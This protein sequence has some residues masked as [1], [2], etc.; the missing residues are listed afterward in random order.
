MD[1]LITKDIIGSGGG[2]GGGGAPYI[3][4]D[5]LQSDSIVSVIDVLSEGEIK[6]LVNG[7]K[8]I[9][10]DGTPIK[11]ADDTMAYDVE[12]AER[13]GLPDQSYIEGFPGS[14]SLHEANLVIKKSQPAIY[15]VVNPLSNSAV[16][17]I[18]LTSG[19]YQQKTNGDVIGGSV[20]FE[21]HT[22]D[23]TGVYQYYNSIKITGKS[24]S[25]YFESHEVKRPS[26]TGQW[27]IKVI[28]VTEDSDTAGLT[29]T[30][31]LVNVIEVIDQTQAYP[32]I[33][34][35]GLKV[36]ARSTNNQVPVRTY[37]VDG[38]ICHIPSNYDPV[39]AT[40]TG[41]W[42]GTFKR[43]WTNNPVWI[44]YELLIN[45][46]FGCGRWVSPDE[47]DV[48]SFYDASVYCD[49]RVDNGKGQLER[50]F[51]FDFKI[52][53]ANDAVKVLNDVAGSCN[54][55]LI[56]E[57]SLYRIQQDR[58]ASPV[59][60]LT[61]ANV[62]DGT[63]VYAGTPN[64]G[65]HTIVNVTYFDRENQHL[66]Q[67]TTVEAAPS[68]LE[69]YNGPNVVN[70]QALGAVTESQAIRTGRWYLETALNQ[71]EVA[72]F[73][74]SFNAFGLRL[75]DVIKIHDE[76]YSARKEQGRVLSVVTQGSTNK[77]YLDRACTY[78]FGDKLSIFDGLDVETVSLTTSGTH[79]YIVLPSNINVT[80]GNVFAFDSTVVG[81]QFRITEIN[82][83]ESN[84]LD[85]VA[86]F[87]DPSKYARIESGITVEQP[88]YT[89]IS[90]GRIKPPTNLTFMLSA[91]V[92][93]EGIR[94]TL[95]VGWTQ[96]VGVTIK[97]YQV[98]WRKDN[99]SWTTSTTSNNSFDIDNVT[100]ANYDVK[101]QAVGI[102]GTTSTAL[103]GTYSYSLTGGTGSLLNPVTNLEV[104][105]VG[106]YTFYDR[107]LDITWA[108]PIQNNVELGAI[109]KDFR[110]DIK[111]ALTDEIIYTDYSPAVP[112]G[113]TRAYTYLYDK[114]K[115]LNGGAAKREIKVTVYC[116]DTNNKISVGNTKTFYN[117]PIPAPSIIVTPGVKSL[118][119]EPSTRLDRITHPDYVETIYCVSDD[120]SFIPS[121]D[122][123]VARGDI[124]FYM[125]TGVESGTTYYCSV[126]YSDSFGEPINWSPVV[127][128]TPA[129]PA[130][131]PE[132]EVLPNSPSD[133][134]GHTGVMYKAPGT[135]EY[136]LYGWDG[137]KWMNT[138]DGGYL[139][140]YSVV[141]SKIY[142]EDLRAISANLGAI[143]SGS[144]TFD[145]TSFIRGGAVTYGVGTG[146]WQG[147]H[148]DT[149]KWR[150]G[151]PGGAGAAWDGT[152]FV[153]YGH[154]G[155]ITLQS[156]QSLTA[157]WLTLL[158]KPSSLSAISA[159]EA[160]KLNGIQAG[161]TVGAPAG[162]L[163]A[164]VDATNLAGVF[165]NFNNSN[166]QNGTPITAPTVLADGT[167]VDHTINTDSS[168]DISFEWTW[169]GNEADI[170]GF[171]VYVY[172]T[173]SSSVYSFGTS[174]AAE[175]VYTVPAQKRAFILFGQPA[176]K[177]YTFGVRAYRK[178]DKN[179]AA[180]GIIQS[181]IVK[182]S[183]SSEN[184]YRPSSSVAFSGDITGTISTYYGQIPAGNVN[185]W[186]AIA[187][188]GK[189]QDYAT[190]GATIGS[191][192]YQG[193]NI[194]NAVVSD[195]T[196]ITAS[197]ISTFMTSAAIGQ[198]YIGVA[199]IGSAQIQDAN[200]TTLKIAG[201]AVTVP[202]G[203]NGIYSASATIN[204]PQP[205]YI[206]VI[207]TFTQGTGKGGHTW[208][209]YVG[210]AQVAFENPAVA[211]TGA[212]S[213]TAYVGAGGQSCAIQCDQQSGDGRCSITVLGSMR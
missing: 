23:S 179:I 187:G 42:D 34:Y 138:R 39:Q 176:N 147:W 122:T 56:R 184:P 88:P 209:L 126:A 102:N 181:S 30:T 105:N 14:E 152:N 109:L 183:I 132:V 2:K 24:T 154:D 115:T 177:Y 8:S 31:Q 78:S 127:S 97:H 82:Q 112:A 203:G 124:P 208:R 19:L 148:T 16:I 199:A 66:P 190:F 175:T 86:I 133:V 195:Q 36:S 21:V 22:A 150:V 171:L 192:L 103:T 75:G 59:A 73:S 156:G 104:T 129:T 29:N 200:V 72:K 4:D 153:I 93:D 213:Y 172:V 15:T 51:T 10:F 107:N 43:D 27:S 168:A 114:N 119:I 207:G 32:D 35:V 204:L 33:A 100:E 157:D 50:R 74:M 49:E 169:S 65:R 98:Q 80:A 9:L 99:G 189:P 3:E 191:N 118:K 158:N 85:I 37:L 113:E 137:D 197:N 155:S 198:A 96:P 186:G 206:T 202:S 101:I 6:G 165:T 106:G 68:E 5:T 91:R 67:V 201:N 89:G 38:L 44:L 47:I 62:V 173:T 120:P 212:M 178:V 25:A 180:S 48:Y 210:G 135:S 111:D 134:N 60:I 141:A 53:D 81:R 130:G 76:N 79:D 151:T 46:R 64:Q 57:G 11:S 92:T 63:F 145:Q 71:N 170:D 95:N 116:R 125:L 174:P 108:N 194:V 7:A 143:T 159:S 28:R 131:I 70:I 83:S 123:A 128:E 55:V 18:G 136:I 13:Y 205:G 90:N 117:P 26:G 211:T 149:Y 12:Y 110:V 94:R 164:G 69:R 160:N 140:D 17:V 58:P 84:V 144:I 41:I 45:D 193:S 166:D 162:T 52:D 142:A 188:A 185:I 163:V 87:H 1:M 77:I 139:V 61:N 121:L 182:P 196:K 20:E 167:A 40:Y 146:I 161:A 54:S